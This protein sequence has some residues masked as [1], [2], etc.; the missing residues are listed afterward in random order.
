[1]VFL[2]RRE[3]FSAAHR[4][5]NADWDEQK[6]EDIFGKCRNIHGHNFQLFVTVKGTPDPSTGFI[7]N[8]QD[9]GK[10][11]RE[12]VTS[13]LDHA[14]LNEDEALLKGQQPTTEVLV[15]AIWNLIE[16][17]LKS[18]QLHCIKLVETENI[19][20]EYYGGQ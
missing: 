17:E 3:R 4:L 19:Y 11:I 10:L 13:R 6:N 5:Y 14:F 15:V 7:I 16:A 8:A 20:V 18:C 9:L 12:Q 1:M 2:T